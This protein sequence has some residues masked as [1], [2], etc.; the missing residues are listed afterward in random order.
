MV[1]LPT[2]DFIILNELKDIMEESFSE[3]M[4]EFRDEIPSYKSRMTEFVTDAEKLFTLTH[5]IKSSSANLGF[6][7]LSENCRKIEEGLRIDATMKVDSLVD[8]CKNELDMVYLEIEK[9]LAS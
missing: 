6:V 7:R 9:I 3:M 5:T 4:I 1:N 2:V 8:E